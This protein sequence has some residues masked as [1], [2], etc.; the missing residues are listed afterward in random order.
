L[1][2]HLAVNAIQERALSAAE[3]E[4]GWRLACQCRV[5][6]PVTIE[7]A[8]MQTSILA[9]T[10]RITGTSQEGLA[11]AVDLGTTT[12]VA[13]V[14]DLQTGE[15]IGV[16]SA[17]N[18]QA[19]HGADIMGRVQFGLTVDGAIFC[20]TVSRSNRP[21]DFK[22]AEKLQMSA[23]SLQGINIVGTQS[24]TICSADCRSNRSHGCHLRPL[25]EM[26]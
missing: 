20:K 4:N 15:V 23:A 16:E 1:Q 3:V 10:T 6:G 13:Q 17:L 2:G 18:A 11:V 7:V 19:R 14:L 8:Q 25:R 22:S 26:N 21:N 9:D 12:L 24:C 5:T